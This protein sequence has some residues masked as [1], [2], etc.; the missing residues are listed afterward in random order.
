MHL[1]SIRDQ[2][3]GFVAKAYG[4]SL[5]FNIGICSTESKVALSTL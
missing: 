2:D 4:V 3:A 5:V 1:G